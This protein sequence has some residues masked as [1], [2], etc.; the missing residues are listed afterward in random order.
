LEELLQRG[1]GGE[2][3]ELESGLEQESHERK[4]AKRWAGCQEAEPQ[5]PTPRTEHGNKAEQERSPP[6]HSKSLGREMAPM[7][8]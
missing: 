3:Q 5:K 2:R 8:H 7:A 6:L 1:R 4:T